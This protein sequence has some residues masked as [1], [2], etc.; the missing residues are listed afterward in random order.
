MSSTRDQ[1]LHVIRAKGPAS[2]AELAE[3]IGISVVSVRHHLASLQ[4]EGLVTATETRRGVGRPHLTYALTEAASERFPS[5][6]VRFSGRLLDEL[7]ATLPPAALEAM[8]TRMGEGIA[9]EHATRLLGL[10]LDE[11]LN[12]LVTLLGTE[13]FMAQWNRVGETILLTEHNCPYVQI[14]QR[15]PEVC[16][17]DQTLIGSLLN[18]E[19]QKT[20]C[21]L[22]GAERC[23]FIITPLK[24]TLISADSL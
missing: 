12:I 20:N 17:I 15:H 23:T 3:A 1:I 10:S 11:K 8:F 19:V 14:G 13:G 22:N 18:A 24:N 7:K 6:Y 4:A 2:I 5:K 21:V 16:A 9:A